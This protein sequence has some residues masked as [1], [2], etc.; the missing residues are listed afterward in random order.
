MLRRGVGHG[1]RVAQPREVVVA[2][3]RVPAAAVRRSVGDG[4]VVVALNRHDAALTQQRDGAVGVRAEAADVAEAEDGLYA[5][6]PSVVERRRQGRHV[7]VDTAEH[8]DAPVLGRGAGES[9]H[10]FR[11]LAPVSRQTRHAACLRAT[12]PSAWSSVSPSRRASGSPARIGQ[13]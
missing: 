1:V 13:A 3:I 8:R 4:R 10:A 2:G 7:A 9:H 11:Q 6:G 12:A 5:A